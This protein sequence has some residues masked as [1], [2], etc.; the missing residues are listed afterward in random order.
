MPG[1]ARVHRSRGSLYVLQIFA[2]NALWPQEWH[3]GLRSNTATRPYLYLD[4]GF[5]RIEKRIGMWFVWSKRLMA[6]PRQLYTENPRI[7]GWQCFA[8]NPS[9]LLAAASG[10]AGEEDITAPSYCLLCDR[11]LR[12]DLFGD[13]RI[14]QA[15]DREDPRNWIGRVF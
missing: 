12:P 1:I 8:P 14:R 15:W 13:Y 4:P 5:G 3:S 6:H 9:Q 10:I 2:L 11:P 7:L